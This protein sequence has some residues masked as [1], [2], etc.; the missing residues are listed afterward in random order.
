MSA[1]LAQYH[2]GPILG[3][4]EFQVS[5]HG[6]RNAGK[7]ILLGSGPFMAALSEERALALGDALIR[8]V[9]ER[10]AHFASQAD[11]SVAVEVQ[12]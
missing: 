7:P 6:S 9:H 10:R 12:L 1:L 4:K 2:H 5:S 8:S 11:V 3:D